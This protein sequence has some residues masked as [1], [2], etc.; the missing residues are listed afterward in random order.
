MPFKKNQDYGLWIENNGP[1]YFGFEEPL[2]NCVVDK[3]VADR[4]TGSSTHC[5]IFF[6]CLKK[7]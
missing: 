3:P 7:Y 2:E 4:G 6:L 5:G 1:H